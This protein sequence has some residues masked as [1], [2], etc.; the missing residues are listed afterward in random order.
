[1]KNQR[2]LNGLVLSIG[3]LALIA[4]AAGLFWPSGGQPYEF[5]TLWNET[6]TINGRGLYS[7]DSLSY[8]AQAQAQDVITLVI[9][10][11]LLW[12]SA[13]FAFRGS[14]RGQLLL[15]GTIGYFLYTYM[16][17]VFS[18]A[19]NPLFL[20]YVALFTLS[21]FAFILCLMSFDIAR[22]PQH[23]SP[24]LPRRGIAVQF[25]AMGSFLLLA[26]L[27]RILP[28]LLYNQPPEDLENTTT[29]VVQGMDLGII[30][31]L[32]FFSAVLLL[33][34]SPWGYLLVSVAQLKFLSYSIAVSAMA[35]G[36]ILAG[37][38]TSPVE[39]AVFPAIT[40]VN[41]VMSIWLLQ[42]VDARVPARLTA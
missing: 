2:T 4:A 19:F 40:L 7:Y 34:R 30:V 10:L 33:K 1:M 20:I 31:P 18:M 29:L 23:F 25:F 27:G 38:E 6:V 42:N 35:L 9:A 5:H 36:Q 3:V 16:M 17:M 14:L 32:T 15:A 12:V 13:R 41:L 11:P 39:T 37:I 24:R 8:A 22:L 21:L 26:W 28:A